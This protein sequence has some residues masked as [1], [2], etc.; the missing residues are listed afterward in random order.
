MRDRG[1][2]FWSGW[3]TLLVVVAAG[4]PRP[5]IAGILQAIIPAAV[6]TANKQGTG[7]KFQIAGTNS[8]TL[9]NLLCNDATG[10]ATDSACGGAAAAVP[11]SGITAGTNTTAA[12][13]VGTGSSLVTSGTG[14]IGLHAIEFTI[15]NGTD[16]ISTGDA[17]V[18]P[19]AA[20]A[21][22][23]IRTDISGKQSGSIT[24]DVWKAAGAIPTSGNKISAS[25]PITLS[26]SQLNQNGSIS[27]WTTSVSSGDVFGFSV[28]TV[29][30]VTQVVGQ[31]WCQ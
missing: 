22:T 1:K 14:R 19:T 25:A 17:G 5:T 12:M 23:I 11:F 10:A 28:A 2:L 31:I 27:G 15:G 7:T 30:T 20:F 24:V 16:V 8:N 9:G 18:Y 21:C 26:S 6:P 13:V 29:G 4:L 3:V